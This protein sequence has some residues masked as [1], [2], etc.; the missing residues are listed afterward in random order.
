MN[1]IAL[2]ALYQ[3]YNGESVER[4]TKSIEDDETIKELINEDKFLDRTSDKILINSRR[5][6]KFRKYYEKNH[7]E[8]YFKYKSF[9]EEYGYENNRFQERDIDNLIKL[10]S[11]LN[12]GEKWIVDIRKEMVLRKES[13]RRASAMFFYNDEK[14]LDQKDG[15][16]DFF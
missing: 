14:H 9:L 1:W 13:V 15:L 12:A 10:K 2:K 16:I 7:L 3:I 5:V 4:K 6:D 8:N 11:S